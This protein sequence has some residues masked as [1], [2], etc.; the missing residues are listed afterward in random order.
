MRKAYEFALNCIGHDAESGEIWRDYI[1]FLKSGEVRYVHL[2]QN[3]IRLTGVTG[4]DDVGSVAENGCRP[5]S[6][7]PCYSG[8]DSELRKIVGRLFRLR[9][10]IECTISMFTSEA[11][12]QFA[13]SNTYYKAKKFLA[14]YQTAYNQARTTYNALQTHASI[15]SLPS[16]DR[17]PIWLPS[18]PT[19]ST[20]D[21]MLMTR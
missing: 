16:A 4:C 18:L 15:L 13:D 21:K 19:F 8:P 7:P 1:E 12:R 14:D 5:K 17:Q 9:D 20:D 10:N 2:C 6:L 3:N 11:I